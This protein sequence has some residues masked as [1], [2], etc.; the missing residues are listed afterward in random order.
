MR[1]PE[2]LESGFLQEVNE[3]EDEAKMPYITSAERLGIKKGIEQGIEQGRR[4]GL[5]EGIELGLELKFGSE[6]LQLLPEISQ[7]QSVEMLKAI[8]VGIKTA[9]TLE[10]LRQIY[11]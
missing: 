9:N 8:Q 4:Q 7:I 5:L 1:L 10:E 2:E 11:Q 6:G 3:Y